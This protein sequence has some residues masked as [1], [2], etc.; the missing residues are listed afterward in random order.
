MNKLLS[1]IVFITVFLSLYGILHLYFYRK[2]IGAFQLDTIS[3]R[4]F[5]FVLGFLLLSPILS[6]LLTNTEHFLLTHILAYIGFVWMGGIFLFF[7]MNLVIDIYRLIIHTSNRILPNFLSRYFPGDRMT[8]MVTLLIIAGI[9]IY[10]RF[11]AKNITVKRVELSTTKLPSPVEQLRIVQISDIHFSTLNGARFAEKIAIIIRDLNPD[12]L[13]STGDFIDRG[14]REKESVASVFRGIHT[15]YGKYA[16]PGNHEFISGIRDAVEFTEK[17]GFKMIRNECITVGDFLNIAGVDDPAARRFG[18]PYTV[19]EDEV[20]RSIHPEQLTIFLKHQPRIEHDNIGK[21]DI[22]ISGHTHNGQIFP[23]TLITSLFYPYQ[24][25][26]F[27]LSEDSCLYVSRGT[28]TWG[29]P[30]RF[31][32]FPEITVIDF[33][34]K[35]NDAGH[36]AVEGAPDANTA[37]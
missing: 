1:F 32:T 27:K 4:G 23:F 30:M 35:G 3:K 22:Q 7:A 29:P 8:F 37:G 33:K 24:K 14:L 12:I 6:Y 13:V 17:A 26:L 36:R 18:I 2:V 34:R 11:E 25:G 19:S 10:G 31:L 16:I 15:P 9:I 21:F 20:L 5:P 28:G